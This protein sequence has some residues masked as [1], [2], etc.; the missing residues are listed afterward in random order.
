M[1]SLSALTTPL[2]YRQ[3][4]PGEVTA[5]YDVVAR[6]FDKFVAP[7]YSAEGV[8]EFLKYARGLGGRSNHFVLLAVSQGTVAGMI[9][10]RNN[11]HISMLFVASEYQGRGISRALIDCALDSCRRD[12]PG[13]VSVTVNSSPYAVPIYEKLGFHATGPEQAIHGLRFTPMV[14]YLPRGE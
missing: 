12:K 7:D 14:L 4:E 11:E 9:E 8:Q 3:M 5:V 6:V 1:G 10:V 2:L 13:L